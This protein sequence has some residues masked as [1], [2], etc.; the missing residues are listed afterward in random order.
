MSG[1][2]GSKA[3]SKKAANPRGFFVFFGLCIA[4]IAAGILWFNGRVNT[5]DCRRLESTRVDCTIQ[6]RWLGLLP[7]E[8]QTVQHLQGA[9][10]DRNCSTD[11]D[12]PNSTETCVYSVDLATASGVVTLSP[13][14]A[15]GGNQEHKYQVAEQINTFVSNPTMPSL[16]VVQTELGPQTIVLGLILLIGLAMVGFNVGKIIAGRRL[17]A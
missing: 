3:G 2:K 16:H 12:D 6:T 17:M 1:K 8:Q 4:V 5:I 9:S 15:S 11:E 14:L 7:L 10:I 13:P